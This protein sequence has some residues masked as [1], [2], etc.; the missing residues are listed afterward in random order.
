MKVLLGI[1]GGIGKHIAATGAIKAAKQRGYEVDVV[2]AHPLALQG[3]TDIHRVYEWQRGEYFFEKFDD[4][5]RVVLN[6]PYRNQKFLTGELSL[7]QAWAELLLDELI[8]A[9]DQFL[10]NYEI[11]LAEEQEILQFI[12]DFKKPILAVQT[13]GGQ[14][15]GWAWTKDMPLTEAAEVLNDYV[16]NAHI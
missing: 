2:C 16:T 6:D 14:H 7:A 4:Y 11:S 8:E 15:A 5:D 9:E 12:K 13:N 10:P 3:N 1:E